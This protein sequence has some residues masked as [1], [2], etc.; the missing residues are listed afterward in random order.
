[1]KRG[2]T[3]IEFMILFVIVGLL[4][5]MLIPMFRKAKAQYNGEKPEPYKTAYG[6]ETVKYEGHLFITYY[7]G[8]FMHHPNCPCQKIKAEHE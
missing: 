1:M 3:L 4:A 7:S 6:F 5:V 8:A 2:F